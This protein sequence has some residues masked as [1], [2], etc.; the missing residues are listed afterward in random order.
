MI[1][2]SALDNLLV[3]GNEIFINLSIKEVSKS[4]RKASFW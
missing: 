2:S 4:C 1:G 3:I